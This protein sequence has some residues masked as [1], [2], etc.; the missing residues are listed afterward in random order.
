MDNKALQGYLVLADI[1]GYTC[2]LAKSELEHAHDI[3]TDLLELIVGKFQP[4]LTLS[5]LEGDAVFAYV[6][7]SSVAQGETLLDLIDSTY[8]AFKDRLIAAH[9]RTSCTCNACRN[10]PTLDLKFMAHF[11][12][13]MIQ[14]VAGIKELVGSDVNAVH[15]LMKNHVSEATG[16]R[17][18]ALF[19]EQCLDHMAI[20]PDG[21]HRQAENYEHLG[22]INTFSLNLTPRY[23]ELVAR[24]R[25]VVE[26]A[27]AS[28]IFEKDI[29]APPP[30][31]W[32]WLNDPEKVGICRGLK[33]DKLKGPDGRSGLGSRNH[34]HHGSSIIVE[35]VLDWRPFDYFTV[36]SIIPPQMKIPDLDVTYRLTPT[37][38]GTHLQVLFRMHM[39]M[40]LPVVRAITKIAMG[41][42]KPQRQFDRLAEMLA[43]S[44][45]QPASLGMAAT[46][47]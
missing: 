37:P 15:R 42:S 26:P 11:G 36:E 20:Q 43:Q 3:L 4:L 46:Q 29:A 5:K 19:T 22:D 18:Y 6:A 27:Q 30:V 17:G 41:I 44:K 38:E 40:P 1:S 47:G 7:D 39:N 33:V 34:C 14:H 28:I 21:M 24:R 31:V 32:E 45:E 9:R 2:F 25:I 10:I 13:F 8:V 23:D 35:T 16:W 12:S